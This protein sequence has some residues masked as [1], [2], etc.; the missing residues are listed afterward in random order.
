MFEY[1][2]NNALLMDILLCL[3]TSIAFIV[4]LLT[5]NAKKKTP[6]TD[7]APYIAL[8]TGMG[9]LALYWLLHIIEVLL[10]V[11]LSSILLGF[12]ILVGAACLMYWSIM[13]TPQNRQK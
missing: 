3:F 11:K 5:F 7:I 9:L 10:S 4:S 8:S 13:I 2:Y 12:L 6:K 1:V